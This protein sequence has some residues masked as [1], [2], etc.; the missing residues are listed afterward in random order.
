MAIFRFYDNKAENV[1]QFTQQ[2][3][4]IARTLG[5]RAISRVRQFLKGDMPL[6][7]LSEYKDLIQ[8]DSKLAGIKKLGISNYREYFDSPIVKSQ[9]GTPVRALI[10]YSLNTP[11]II[12]EP[13]IDPETG[14]ESPPIELSPAKK[15]EYTD[16]AVIITVK[17]PKN[18][19]KT[20][21]QG[22]DRS[23]KEYI[24][25]GDYSISIKS[26]IASLYPEKFPEEELK[27]LKQIF[28]SSDSISIYSPFLSILGIDGLII[29]DWNV[30]QIQGSYNSF[31]YSLTA[32][33]EPAKSFV[34]VEQEDNRTELQKK[35]GAVNEWVAL[36]SVFDTITI[37]G[38]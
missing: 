9:I 23:R 14:A 31:T 35:L 15:V 29:R 30:S 19:V 25:G 13:F 3:T 28:S 37:P 6:A 2:P 12:A 26:T 1:K 4:I 33:Y 34:V 22:R 16:P 5:N 36:D 27:T 38:L 24:A 18:I 10:K 21:V 17:N 7:Q 32:D 8:G 20:Q 11:A